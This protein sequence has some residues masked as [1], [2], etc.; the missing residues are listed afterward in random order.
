M[1]PKLSKYLTGFH[2]N[3]NTQHALLKMI[4][5]LCALLNKDNKVA[6]IIMDLSKAFD[7]LNHNLLC[8]LKAYGFSEN[9]NRHQQTKVGHKFSKWQKISAGLP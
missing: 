4:E 7:T 3:Y 2:A 8:K 9:A 6:A 1:E 5:T